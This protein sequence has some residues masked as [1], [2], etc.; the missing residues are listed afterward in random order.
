[1]KKL[2]TAAVTTAV[3]MAFAGSALATET[4]INSL[5]AAGGLGGCW[6]GG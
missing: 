1:M 4:R 2:L 5:S 6:S 3:G